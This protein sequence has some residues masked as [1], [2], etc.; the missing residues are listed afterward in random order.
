MS[1]RD[2]REKG[3]IILLSTSKD[4]IVSRISRAIEL[5]EP[6]F[7]KKLVYYLAKERKSTRGSWAE[8]LNVPVSKNFAD[9]IRSMGLGSVSALSSIAKHDRIDMDTTDL[10]CYDELTRTQKV[11]LGRLLRMLTYIQKDSS[12]SGKLI[13]IRKEKFIHVEYN[14]KIIADIIQTD[15]LESSEGE[16]EEIGR[17][18]V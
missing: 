3:N 7:V 6:T 1:I 17:A 10:F 12:P 15:L 14:I 4:K 5:G 2:N 18:H 11:T 16:V 8:I 13:R 9:V